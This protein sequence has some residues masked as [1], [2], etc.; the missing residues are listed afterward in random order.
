[1]LPGQV[2]APLEASVLCKDRGKYDLLD[3]T[4]E[5]IK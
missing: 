4:S 5:V 2:S 3:R 1:M